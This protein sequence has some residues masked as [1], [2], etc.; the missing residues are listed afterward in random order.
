[1]SISSS[2][3]AFSFASSVSFFRI[4]SLPAASSAFFARVA[5]SWSSFC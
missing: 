5:I 1:M 2:F 3:C 4:A